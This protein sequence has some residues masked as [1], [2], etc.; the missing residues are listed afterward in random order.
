MNSEVEV[1]VCGGGPAGIAA[2][3]AAAEAG[4]SALIVEKWGASGRD[5][6]PRHGQSAHPGRT[7][8]STAGAGCDGFS[9]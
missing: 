6:Y 8:R 4:C 9:S 1:L 3:I 5:G 2:A 7:G